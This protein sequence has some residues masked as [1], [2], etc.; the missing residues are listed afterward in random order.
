MANVLKISKAVEVEKRKGSFSVMI[1]T[2]TT[3]EGDLWLSI[4]L[5]S[6]QQAM[7]MITALEHGINATHWGYE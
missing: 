1:L 4:D 2:E 6:R 5:K 3:E 7:E